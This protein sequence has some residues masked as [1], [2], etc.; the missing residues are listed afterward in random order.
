[1][2]DSVSMTKTRSL[3]A[4]ALGQLFFGLATIAFGVQNILYGDFV[5]GR[6]PTWPAE[7]KGQLIWAYAS[8]AL[9]II[10]GFL[11]TSGKKARMAA[12]VVALVCFCMGIP[13]SSA[14]GKLAMGY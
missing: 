12:L 14:G 10:A 13:A 4:V 5:M 1:M 7:W 8:G 6:A 3:S 9:L 2:S 11:I